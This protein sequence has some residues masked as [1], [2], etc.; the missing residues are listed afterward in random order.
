MKGIVLPLIASLVCLCVPMRTEGT[1]VVILGT[2]KIMYL[3]TDSVAVDMPRG[4]PF[5]TCKIKRS[6]TFFW[7]HK[8]FTGKPQSRFDPDKTVVQSIKFGGSFNKVARAYR[9]AMM[10][11]LQRELPNLRST[12]P[13]LYDS[14]VR[15]HTP[16]LQLYIVKSDIRGIEAGIVKFSVIGGTLIHQ[17]VKCSASNPICLLT[18]AEPAMQ[19]YIR[20]HNRAI[21]DK[22]IDTIKHMMEIARSANPD[23]IGP[24]YSILEIGPFGGRWV[25]QGKCEDI[26]TRKK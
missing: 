9:K 22:P 7:A 17:F 12:A 21:A 26:P 16:I 14:F 10:P 25:Q 18:S 5:L 4:N 24:P 6:E 20:E 1:E 11:I 2:S 3:A 19:R 8:G 23:Y 13:T 15:D